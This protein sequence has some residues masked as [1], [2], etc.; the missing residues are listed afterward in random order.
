MGRIS[1]YYYLSHHT[2]RH[3]TEN[4]KSELSIDELLRVLSDAHEYNELPVRHNEDIMNGYDFNLFIAKFILID[5]NHN[6]ILFL[7]NFPSYVEYQLIP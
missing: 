4:L 1:S 7:V 2:M 6:F 5:F 3:F